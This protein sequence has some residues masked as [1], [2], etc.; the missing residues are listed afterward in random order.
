LKATPDG[1]EVQ[2][3]PELDRSTGLDLFLDTFWCNRKGESDPPVFVGEGESWYIV[4]P[5]TEEEV[6][7][8]L[9]S[10]PRV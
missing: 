1:V 5:A 8:Y 6:A 3:R 7:S 2:F 4:S 10:N 9:A